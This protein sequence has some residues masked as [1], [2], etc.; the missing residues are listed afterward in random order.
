METKDKIL[1]VAFTNFLE[2]GYKGTTYS[3]LIKE[4]EVVKGSFY[5]YFKNKKELYFAVI[6]KYFLS[7][8]L[9]V[10]WEKMQSLKPKNIDKTLSHIYQSYIRQVSQYTSKGLSRYFILFFEALEL[11]PGF[12]SEVQ[13][14]Y[15][16][17]EKFI[18][19]NLDNKTVRAVDYIAKYEGYLFWLGVFPDEKI[20]TIVHSK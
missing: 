12:K 14:F 18:A 17:L 11:Y 10:D 3:N 4:S 15:R 5:Y 8:F 13:H 20:E 1:Q 19:E 7:Y 6:D 9:Q 16:L 2:N